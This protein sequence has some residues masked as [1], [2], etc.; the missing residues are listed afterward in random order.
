MSYAQQSHW[1]QIQSFLPTQY[2]LQP[3]QEPSEEWWQHAGHRVHLDCYRNSQAPF[4]VILLH[5]VGTNGR[6]MQM[7]LGRPLAMRGVETIAVDMPGYGVT[8][9]GKGALVSYDDWVQIGCDLIDAEL[10]RDD[11]PIVLYGLSAGGMETF[12]I[13]A[14][15]R[16]VKGIV[17]MTFLDQSVQQVRDTTA[18]NRFM[19][20]VGVPMA[21]AIDGTPLARLR[22]P[23]ALAGK[24]HTLVNNRAALKACLK[25]R[26]SAGSWVSMRFLTSYMYYQPACAPEDFDVCPVLLTQP[27]ADRWTPLDLS[28]LFLKRISKV[29]VDTVMLDNAGHFPLEQPGLDQMVEAIYRFCVR[30]T[31]QGL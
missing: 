27:A 18:L 7:I 22:M 10:A 12:H 1:R 3:G 25:D 23:M 13:A 5:G 28:Q 30:V 9:V 8:E 20:R 15:S 21:K 4:K 2:Q 6:Q 19:S 11:R 24:M 31:A 29:P 17:G 26:S 16:K 14:R